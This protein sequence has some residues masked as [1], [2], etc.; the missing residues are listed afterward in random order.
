[1]Y[2]YFLAEAKGELHSNESYEISTGHPIQASAGK[3][4]EKL[5]LFDAADLLG[6]GCSNKSTRIVGVICLNDPNGQAEC[7]TQCHPK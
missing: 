3:A 7:I 6:E 2:K 1:M 5:A 4:V